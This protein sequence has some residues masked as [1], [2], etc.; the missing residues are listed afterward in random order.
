VSVRVGFGLLLVAATA[1]AGPVW[2]ALP[3]APPCG[4]ESIASAMRA[5]LA[6]EL[7]EGRA[8]RAA[9]VQISVEPDGRAWTLVIAAPGQVALRRSLGEALDCSAFSEEAALIADRYLQ[10]IAWSA[11]PAE[12]NRLPPPPPPPPLQVLLEVGGGGE[13]GLSGIT[14]GGALQAG[15]RR[16]PWQLEAGFAFLGTGQLRLSTSTPI[17]ATLTQV[18]SA[19]QL[20]LGRLVPFGPFAAR[21]ELLGGAEV[22]FGQAAP[23]ASGYPNPVLHRAL[24]VTPLGFLGARVG[25]ELAVTARFFFALTVQGRAHLGQVRI[26]V[27]GYPEHFV[28]RL[29]DGGA[30]LSVGFLF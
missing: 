8:P 19:A 16:G 4:F 13:L 14:P 6:V 24:T 11:A 10:S 30:G 25:V 1:N 22:F 28:T 21:F 5:R 7:I 12:V 27:E 9:E 29:V 18:S 15:V 2:L 23:D 20:A 3:P 26:E 17:G